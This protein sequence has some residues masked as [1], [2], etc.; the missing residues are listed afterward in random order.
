M[1]FKNTIFY[2]LFIISTLGYSQNFVRPGEWKKY[3]QEVFISTGAS[4][5]LGDLGGRDR[6]GT[7][8][9]PIDLNLTQ[10]R[11]AFGVGYLYKVKRWFNVSGKFNWLILRGND[12]Q[13]SEPYRQNRNL[14]FKTNIF[15]LSGRLEFGFLS[16]KVGNRYGIKRTFNRRMKNNNWSL[17]GF[18]GV[19]FFYFNPYSLSGTAL[20][21]LHTEGEGLPGGPSNYSNYQVCIPIGLYYKYIIN[22]QWTIGVEF[23][24]RKTFT[25]YIDDVSGTYYDKAKLMAAYGPTAV[26][27]ADPSLGLIPGATLPNANGTGAQRGDP[28]NYDSYLS[29]EVTV[30]YII[31][32]KRKRARLRSKF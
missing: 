14:N 24:W 27:F 28:S 5:F 2:I 26:H 20:K 1:S 3:R 25:D 32:Q 16:N 17:F 29:L 31:K 9:S 18:V 7:H 10:T 13:T 23:S 30:G 15:E 11:T 8:Y 4:G 19:G 12:A 21:P 22:K 6:I